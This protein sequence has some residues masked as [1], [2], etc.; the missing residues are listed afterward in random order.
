MPEKTLPSSLSQ[1]RGRRAWLT[2]VRTYLQCDALLALRLAAAGVRMGEHEVLIN[3]ARTP[4]MTQQEL[5]QHSFSAKSGISM[6]VAHM[7]KMGLV[8]R[9]ADAQDARIK[10]V[11]LT[12]DGEKLALVCVDIQ[13]QLAL[14]M[15]SSFSD[16]ELDMVEKLMLRASDALGRLTR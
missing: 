13:A 15:T 11:T 5:A 2:V 16:E 3:L 1:T 6:L 12:A 9:N 10:R 14:Q 4:G 8:Q 7:E